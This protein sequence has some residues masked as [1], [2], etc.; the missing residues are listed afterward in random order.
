MEQL[1][2]N[3][4]ERLTIRAVPQKDVE[5]ACFH[6]VNLISRNCEYLE[7]HFAHTGADSE[8]R[9]AVADISAANA[10][11]DRSI[12][13]V[14]T[15]LEFLGAEKLP[16][17]GPVDLCQLLQQLASQA[18]TIRA[19]L[20]VELEVDCGGW[21]TCRVMARREEA[22][23]L[24]LHLLSNALRACEEG[25]RVQI[26]LRR[27]ETLWLLTMQDNGCGLPDSSEAAWLENRR[28][29]MGGAKLGLL[30]CQECCR[31][32]SWGMQVKED[33]NGG[34]KAEVTIPLS[35]D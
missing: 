27:S 5:Q 13:E 24:L 33:P 21:R 19:Q 18:D 14:M 28:H 29:F 22:E 15:L 26:R 11:L 4:P 32:M 6:S 23:L 1:Q 16:P 8:A 2:Q 35:T 10:Q 20:K 30:L 31:R 25:G 3:E 9:Q 34:T 17:L 7:Q 12:N